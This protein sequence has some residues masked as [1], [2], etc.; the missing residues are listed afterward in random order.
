MWVK[1]MHLWYL[2]GSRVVKKSMG[3][4]HVNMCQFTIFFLHEA[5]M[6]RNSHNVTK[7]L[8]SDSD[9]CKKNGLAWL[10]TCLILLVILLF[11]A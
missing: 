2:R 9:V 11:V 5:M 10:V 1:V 4:C 8:V 6:D 3:Y 7:V